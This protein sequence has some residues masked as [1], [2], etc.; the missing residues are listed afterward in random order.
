MTVQGVYGRTVRKA[1]K[2]RGYG[3]KRYDLALPMLPCIR[4]WLPSKLG[5]VFY[6]HFPSLFTRLASPLTLA[7]PRREAHY[8][9]KLRYGAPPKPEPKV[10]N[11]ILQTRRVLKELHQYPPKIRA[12][13]DS[14]ADIRL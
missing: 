13:L 4:T 5:W 3:A 10:N 14:A 11:Y 1:N 7:L 2:G 12:S 6:G 9:L 8:F